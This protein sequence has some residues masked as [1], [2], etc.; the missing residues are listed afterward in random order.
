M[1]QQPLEGQGCLVFEASRLNS[2]TPHPVELPWTSDQPEAETSTL[3]NRQT[4]LSPEGF[5]P[6]IQASKRRQTYGLDGAATG[7]GQNER[8]N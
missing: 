7:I 6:T 5:E 2:D 4:Y 1:A 8:E 3:N